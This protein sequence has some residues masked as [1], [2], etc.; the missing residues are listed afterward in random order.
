MHHFGVSGSFNR[1]DWVLK[2][3][4]VEN[5]GLKSSPFDITVKN[6]YNY[7]SFNYKTEKLGAFKIMGGLDFSNFEDT[8]LGGGASYSY[9][10]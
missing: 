9:S 2:S 7:I 6:W 10:F 1:V 8:V 5:F 3:S 4:Y